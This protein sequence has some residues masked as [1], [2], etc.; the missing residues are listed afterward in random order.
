VLPVPDDLPFPHVSQVFLIERYVTGLHGQPVPAVASLGVASPEP[1]RADAADLA[2]GVLA[3]LAR[4][5]KTVAVTA[6]PGT[7]QV[8]AETG[9]AVTAARTGS[10]DIRRH[11][12]TGLWLTAPPSRARH[13]EVSCVASPG[14]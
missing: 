9:T 10:R 3:G 12:G 14:R 7:I 8:A 2:G 13:R 11:K 5:R 1:S 6:G 4:A